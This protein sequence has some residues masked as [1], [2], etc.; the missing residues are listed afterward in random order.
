MMPGREE[1]A[2]LRERARRLQA[3]HVK[4]LFCRSTRDAWLRSPDAVLERLGLPADAQRLI[5][6][7]GSA[8]FKAEAH[9]RRAVVERS[10]GRVFGETTALLAR[11]AAKSGYAGSDPTFDDFLCSDYFLD[12]HKGLPHTFGIGPGYENISKYFFWLRASFGLRRQDTELDLRNR[13]YS[14]FAAY[15]LGQLKRPHDAF[16]DRFEGGIYWPK[17]PGRLLP[18]MLLSDKLVLF[19]VGNL[20]TA[21]EIRKSGMVNLDQLAPQPWQDEET[22]V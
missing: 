13:A 8:Q 17:A 12:P 5:A 4:L 16:Y 14:E 7:I 1:E 10:I 2:A 19:T 21:R 20:H 11:R 3:L 18:V 9:G 22:L 6:D 15:L